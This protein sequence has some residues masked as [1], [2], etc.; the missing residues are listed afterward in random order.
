MDMKANLGS[1][2]AALKEKGMWVMNVVLEDGPNRL[3]IIYDRGLI[4]TIHNWCE[5]FSTYPR[6][7]DL[8]HAWTLFSNIEKNA[9]KGELVIRHKKLYL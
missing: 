8:L 7:Y 9:W 4:G 1:F 5:A 6:T 3:K 2:G